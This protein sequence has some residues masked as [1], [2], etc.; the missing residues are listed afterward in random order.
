MD[1]GQRAYRI[2]RMTDIARWKAR[3]AGLLVEAAKEQDSL[4]YDTMRGLLLQ[5][6]DAV[7]TT[8]ATCRRVLAAVHDQDPG[9]IDPPE[10]EDGVYV[11][12]SG[13]N[14]ALAET[15]N[16]I[17]AEGNGVA[18]VDELVA[19]LQ[20]FAEDDLGSLACMRCG[21]RSPT[22]ERYAG[23]AADASPRLLTDTEDA[24]SDLQRLCVGH[25]LAVGR[26][27]SEPGSVAGCEQEQVEDG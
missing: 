10:E 16:T 3:G 25:R 15:I 17:S 11:I 18:V 20:Q 14:P 19:Q 26:D 23:C 22:T 4:H 21:I 9:L 7:A 12:R 6:D 2:A 8:L 13:S 1:A 24:M 27:S 5:I